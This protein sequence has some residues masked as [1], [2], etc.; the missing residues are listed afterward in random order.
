MV[1]VIPPSVQFNYG[2]N[3]EYQEAMAR[4]RSQNEECDAMCD[5][6]IEEAQS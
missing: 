6:L 2:A 5:L 1:V 4:D 3:S